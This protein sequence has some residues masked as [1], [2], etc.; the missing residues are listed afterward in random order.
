MYTFTRTSS[1]H[2]FRTIVRTFVR[3]P[4][5]NRCAFSVEACGCCGAREGVVCKK[6][7]ARCL[8]RCSYVIIR[9]YNKSRKPETNI[10]IYI[11]MYIYIYIVIYIYIYI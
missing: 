11:Y 3:T 8:E 4:S 10:Y 2:L 6:C 9:L 5:R 1:E 7:S